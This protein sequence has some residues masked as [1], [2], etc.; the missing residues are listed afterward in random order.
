[1]TQFNK[2][3]S[4]GSM[5]IPASFLKCVFI[6]I[7][8]KQKH[9]TNKTFCNSETDEKFISLGTLSIRIIQ[10]KIDKDFTTLEYIRLIKII[11]MYS[12]VNVVINATAVHVTFVICQVVN[13]I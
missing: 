7:N 13:H 2:I 3:H 8:T 9:N 11:L 10:H 4:I 6:I 1:M 5:K 12:I